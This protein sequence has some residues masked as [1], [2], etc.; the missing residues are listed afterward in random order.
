MNMSRRMMVSSA[1][2]G[3]VMPRT[4][5]AAAPRQIGWEDL[6]PKGVPYGEIIGPGE[7]DEANDRWL[8]EFDANAKKLNKALHGAYIKMP[9]YVLPLDMSSGGVT[10]FIMVPYVGACIHTPPPPANQLVFVDTKAPWPSDQMWDPVWVTGIMRHEM[11][12]TSIA[13]IG[14]AMTAEKIE[15]Y[16]W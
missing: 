3:A 11:Q 6:I 7:I 12:S 14:Y 8:P 13:E 15:V 2:A 9:G 10:S 4:A 1:F 5:F 16:E